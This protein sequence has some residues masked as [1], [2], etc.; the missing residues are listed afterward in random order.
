MVAVSW[1]TIHHLVV[2][3]AMVMG[4]AG[5]VCALEGERRLVS[6]STSPWA[7]QTLCGAPAQL[8]GSIEVILKSVSDHLGHVAGHVPI[9]VPEQV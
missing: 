3:T 4:P 6:V 7:V 8:D 1:T 9:A 5:I 2:L